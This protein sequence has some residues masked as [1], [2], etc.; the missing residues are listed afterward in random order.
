VI[1]NYSGRPRVAAATWP[2]IYLFVEIETVFVVVVD[3]CSSDTVRVMLIVTAAVI[4]VMLIIIVL[5]GLIIFF[6]RYWK[7]VSQLSI[8]HPPSRG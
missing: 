7:M 3:V 6:S 4:A 8:N 2:C 5:F 1:C